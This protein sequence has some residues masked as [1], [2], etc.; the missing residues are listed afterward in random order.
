[1]AERYTRN[2]HDVNSAKVATHDELSADKEHE[3][4]LT[5]VCINYKIIW[6]TL[7]CIT[8][9]YTYFFG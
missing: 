6:A 1:M 9:C 4:H 3:E 7:C 5:H 8:H 2:E